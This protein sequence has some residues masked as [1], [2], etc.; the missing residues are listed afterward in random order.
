MSTSERLTPRNPEEQEGQRP[1]V[2]VDL[3][4]CPTQKPK[5][6]AAMEVWEVV[7][8]PAGIHPR[9]QTQLPPR[10]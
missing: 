2:L 10:S 3:E 1:E 4:G 7:Q 6:K 9:L 8:P 5:C